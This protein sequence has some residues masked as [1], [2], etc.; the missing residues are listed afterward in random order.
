M[1][2]SLSTKRVFTTVPRLVGADQSENRRGSSA[3]CAEASTPGRTAGEVPGESP[4]QPARVSPAA[5]G[6]HISAEP[7]ASFNVR[8]V[9][10]LSFPEFRRSSH[11]PVLVRR[12]RGPYV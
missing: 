12:Q 7:T 9:I 4:R 8:L 1:K 3:V 2:G 6:T 10:Y 5:N 11:R